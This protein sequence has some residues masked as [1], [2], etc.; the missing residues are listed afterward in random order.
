MEVST[1]TNA[2]YDE[3]ALLTEISAILQ[4]MTADWDTACT[5]GVTCD[6][7]LIGD[8]SFESIDIVQFIV[9]IEE[10]FDRHNLP[11]EQL[12]MVDGRYVEELTVN[13]VVAFLNQQL[14][15]SLAGGP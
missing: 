5:D 15:S 3:E 9:A 1:L 8:L 10:R 7:R 11:F 12:L 13:D 4:S 14:P 2:L 6:T